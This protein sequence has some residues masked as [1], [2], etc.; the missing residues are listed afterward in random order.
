MSGNRV[1]TGENVP[2]S[3]RA[4]H[5]DDPAGSGHPSEA[6]GN[7]FDGSNSCTAFQTVASPEEFDRRQPWRSSD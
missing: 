1:R 3:L 5:I 7:P 6:L 2:D 4:G